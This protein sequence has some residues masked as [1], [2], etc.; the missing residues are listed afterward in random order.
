VCVQTRAEHATSG[1]VSWSE[2]PDQCVPD[3]RSGYTCL[4]GQCVSKCNPVCFDGEVC[5]DEGECVLRSTVEGPVEKKDKSANSIVNLH[6]DVLGLL[7]FGLT[8]TLEIGKK[9]SGYLRVRPLNTGMASYYVLGRNNDDFQWGLGGT[10]GMHIFS[11][12]KGNMRGVF[13]GPALEYVYVRQHD[14]VV[15][16]AV[17]GTHSLIPQLDAGY[18]W[19]F[20]R[21]LLGV[22]GRVG[23]AIPIS[24]FDWGRGPLGCAFPSSCNRQRDLWFV[25]GISLDIGVFL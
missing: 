10:L 9:F 7:Q 25:G 23:L 1:G 4:R 20:N 24:E 5:T 18:R 8:P 19:A 13:G 21:L 11:A 14:R 2:D 12:G 15:D 16:R 6:M 3:C 22:G 17:Y